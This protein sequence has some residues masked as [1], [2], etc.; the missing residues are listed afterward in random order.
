MKRSQSPDARREFLE[1]KLGN[2]RRSRD[3][4]PVSDRMGFDEWIGEA[5]RELAALTTSDCPTTD[6]GVPAF[7]G[8][9]LAAGHCRN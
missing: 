5:E 6:A 9:E 7:A 3:F 1:R 4:C 8:R 2:Y